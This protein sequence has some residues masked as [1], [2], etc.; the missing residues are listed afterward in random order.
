MKNITKIF[1]IILASAIF[2]SGCSDAESFKLKVKVLSAYGG[3]SG[4]YTA[5]AEEDQFF[6][7][8]NQT[9]SFYTYEKDVELDNEINITAFPANNNVTYLSIKI[10]QSDLL[11][12]EKIS[13]NTTD[14]VGT[15]SLTYKL[16]D[17]ESE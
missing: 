11:A 12:A 9:D 6:S 10:Y 2:I 13:E 1:I 16:S 5:D 17:T 14:G 15:V 8:E 7:N 4:F 3:F